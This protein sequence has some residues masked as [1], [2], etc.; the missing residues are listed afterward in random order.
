MFVFAADAAADKV[1]KWKSR[2]SCW[3]EHCWFYLSFD[4]CISVYALLLLLCLLFIFA[5]DAT[6]RD[7]WPTGWARRSWWSW[8]FLIF[9][10]ILNSHH[11]FTA[12][13]LCICLYVSLWSPAKAWDL[14][15]PPGV[16]SRPYKGV[17]PLVVFSQQSATYQCPPQSPSQRPTLA[18]SQQNTFKAYNQEGWGNRKGRAK[19]ESIDPSNS[20]CLTKSMLR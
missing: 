19:T 15:Y 5:A 7:V 3:T 11:F 6:G 4:I 14:V 10:W 18:F 13:F 8:W 2:W 12:Y 1:S 16:M 9:Y 17:P 20:Y